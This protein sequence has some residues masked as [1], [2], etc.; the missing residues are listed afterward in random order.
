MDLFLFCRFIIFAVNQYT[1]LQQSQ[2]LVTFQHVYCHNIS[3]LQQYVKVYYIARIDIFH[4]DRTINS[5]SIGSVNR[6]SR[7]VTPDRAATDQRYPYHC[8]HKDSPRR[9]K[10]EK[11]SST[12]RSTYIEGI[13]EGRRTT[14]G[15]HSS[16]PH[17][18][19][20]VHFRKWRYSVSFESTKTNWNY[21]CVT[22]KNGCIQPSKSA[23]TNKMDQP[24]E[25]WKQYKYFR[26]QRCYSTLY[27][28]TAVTT[29][30]RM[31]FGDGQAPR[32]LK[33]WSSHHLSRP[34]P[35]QNSVG[36]L[37]SRVQEHSRVN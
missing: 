29:T 17:K 26:L 10:T 31:Q 16:S 22:K 23:A 28:H 36:L 19:Q 13:S 1:S 8:F 33:L 11:I 5:W 35:L 7:Q 34:I 30:S 12:W 20:H 2:T 25:R 21:R 37:V 6:P 3:G 4:I 32:W 14:L 27:Y 24:P 9:M 15:D 18:H